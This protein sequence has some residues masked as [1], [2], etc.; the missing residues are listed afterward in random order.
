MSPRGEV[1]VTRGVDG[2]GVVSRSA[3]G[4]FTLACRTGRARDDRGAAGGDILQL[5]GA[6]G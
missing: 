1:E 3:A 2:V 6:L 5:W 4:L